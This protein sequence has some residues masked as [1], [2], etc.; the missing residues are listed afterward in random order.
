MR[1]KKRI[2]KR[3]AL[4]TYS[5]INFRHFKN[6]SLNKMDIIYLKKFAIKFLDKPLVNYQKISKIL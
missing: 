6:N 5:K 4:V 1:D 2:I 3:N